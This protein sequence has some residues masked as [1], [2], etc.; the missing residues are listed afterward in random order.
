MHEIAPGGAFSQD[1]FAS[2]ARF[3]SPNVE[4]IGDGLW[5]KPLRLQEFLSF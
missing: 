2:P 4:Q 3:H 5:Q 1:W